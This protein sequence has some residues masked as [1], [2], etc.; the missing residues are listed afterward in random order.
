MKMYVLTHKHKDLRG[1]RM[2]FKTLPVNP[3]ASFINSSLPNPLLSRPVIL[4]LWVMTPLQGSP[5]MIGK[6][7]YLYYDS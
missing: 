1:K 4:N 7:T 2:P 5:K 3:T 6:Q